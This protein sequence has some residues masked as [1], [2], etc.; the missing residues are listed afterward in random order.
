MSGLKKIKNIRD[1]LSKEATE[2]LVL[3][4]VISHLDYANGIFIGVHS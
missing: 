2:V 1:S 3:G 4:V